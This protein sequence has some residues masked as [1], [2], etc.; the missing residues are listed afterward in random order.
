ML[1]LNRILPILF[2][3]RK[4]IFLFTL[5]IL[6]LTA[7]LL[8]YT[9]REYKSVITLTPVNSV[10]ADPTLHN[11]QSKDNLYSLFGSG[12]DIE[13]MEASAEWKNIYAELVHEFQLDTVFHTATTLKFTDSADLA[14]DSA[15]RYHEAEEILLKK[16]FARTTDKGQLQ[17]IAW[18]ISPDMSEQLVTAF[19]SKINAQIRAAWL[20]YFNQTIHSWRHSLDSLEAAYIQLDARSLTEKNGN[21]TLREM[22]KESLKS[23]ILTNRTNI[24][25]WEQAKVALPP[26]FFVFDPAR[27][28]RH[29]YRPNG[30]W[31]L[32][33]SFF[34]A[35]LFGSL[36]VL[37]SQRHK[38]S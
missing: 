11:P 8:Y 7:I 19:A 23:L 30:W 20:N 31:V 9:P 29:D 2:D 13:R 28:D 36:V 1:H 32:L 25:N 4:F 6:A 22:E 33:G 15:R 37:I 18:T 14:D 35:I 26:S 3:N 12:D 21:G 24:G 17:L 16:L 27:A 34:A 38:L 5:S 10:L